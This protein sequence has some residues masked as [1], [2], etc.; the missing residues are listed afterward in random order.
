MLA[1]VGVMFVAFFVHAA[2]VP[3]TV[4]GNGLGAPVGP[5]AELGVAEPF[6]NLVLFEGSQVRGERPRGDGERLGVGGGI[7]RGA[8]ESQAEQACDQVA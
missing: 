3:I 5:D 2:R 6:R 4:H 8:G 1:V 7:G